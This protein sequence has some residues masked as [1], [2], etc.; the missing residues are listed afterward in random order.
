MKRKRY[1]ACFTLLFLTFAAFAF[2][3]KPYIIEELRRIGERELLEYHFYVKKSEELADN[4]EHAVVEI[5]EYLA[6]LQYERTVT[7]Q[8]M[9][10]NISEAKILAKVL[11]DLALY[12]TIRM[13]R[14]VRERR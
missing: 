4:S 10:R 1:V 14:F 7:A 12:M 11:W 6:L 3:P 13:D 2:E 9:P 8:D 5:L